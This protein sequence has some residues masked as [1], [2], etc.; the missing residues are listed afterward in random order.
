MEHFL[1]GEGKLGFELKS[2]NVLGSY[3]NFTAY[4]H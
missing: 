1:T 3:M 4:C 2:A